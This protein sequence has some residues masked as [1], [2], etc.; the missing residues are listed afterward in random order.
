M[1]TLNLGIKKLIRLCKLS[2]KTMELDVDVQP[3]R[4]HDDLT[5]LLFLHE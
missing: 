5:I 3:N 1:S 2:V 4:Y